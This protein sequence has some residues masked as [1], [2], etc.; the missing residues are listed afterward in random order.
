MSMHKS[1]KGTQDKYKRSVRKRYERLRSLILKEKWD[2]EHNNI[3]SLPK[4][5][6]VR[7]KIKKEKKEG[8][9][10]VTNDNMAVYAKEA[11]KKTKK[12]SKDIGKIK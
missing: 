4:E 2:R 5:K 6:I 1:L 12:K 3:F 11:E 7:L 8:T 10:T 9:D